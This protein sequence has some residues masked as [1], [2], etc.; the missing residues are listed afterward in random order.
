MHDTVRQ[1]G[2]RHPVAET[3]H[4]LYETPGCAVR[5]LLK[6]E[7]FLGSMIWEPAAGR[8]A[9]ARELRDFGFEVI[10]RDLIAYDGADRVDGGHDFFQVKHAPAHCRAIVTN[11]PFKDADRFVRHAL[12]LVPKVVVLQRLA[13]LEGAG[14]SDLIDRHLA[15]LYV[16]IERLPMMHRDGWDGPRIPDNAAPFAW[17]VFE[18]D[19]LPGRGFHG[20]RISWREGAA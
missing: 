5:A 6:I 1:R 9:I 18:R 14:R 20:L 7:P 3:G 8:G 15:R 16:G 11:P 10:A 17:F 12:T 2:A 13:A 4:Q 19:H